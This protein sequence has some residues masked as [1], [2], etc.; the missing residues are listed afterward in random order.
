MSL[1]VS[2]IIP[3]FNAS[4]YIKETINSILLQKEIDFEIII[5][6]DG[7][8]DKTKEIIDSFDDKR[9]FY[10]YQH[11]QGVSAARN[12]GLEKAKGE[13]IIFFDADDVMLENF[14]YS[15]VNYLKQH[16]ELDFISGELLKFNGKEISNRIYRGVSPQGANEILLYNSDVVTCPSNYVF[17]KTFLLS[18][19]LKFNSLLS[20][21]ADR[22]FLL[23][24]VLK[25]RTKCVNFDE[26]LL[27]RI[28]KNSMSAQLNSKLVNDNELFYKELRAYSLIPQS[29]KKESLKKGYYILSASFFKIFDL[30]KALFYFLQLAK[31][32]AKAKL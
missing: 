13:F 8:T 24:C 1:Q 3:A 12:E 5:I 26:K 29:I 23:Q 21:T 16:S 28:S 25:G 4:L 15:R 2:I 18:N 31:V 6:D 11:N 32:F 30:K 7:S 27:Y 10:F 22:F 19:H 14:L 20:S 9:I 17:K